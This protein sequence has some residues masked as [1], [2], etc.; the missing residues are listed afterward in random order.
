[1]QSAFGSSGR[2]FIAQIEFGW[3][4]WA[5][6][7][8]SFRATLLQKY[9]GLRQ[10]IEVVAAQIYFTGV[11][12]LPLVCGLAVVTGGLVLLQGVFN[13]QMFGGANW[14]GQILV[15][16]IVRELGPLLTA[17]VVIARSGTAIASEVGN[18]RANREI[19]AL[20]AMGI[21][22]LSYIVF[23][24]LIGGVVSLVCL[25]FFFIVSALAGGYLV[26]LF[27]VDLSLSFYFESLANSLSFADGF[28][29]LLKTTVSGVMIFMIAS[30]CGLSVQRSPTEVP[31]ATTQAVVRSIMAVV[32]FHFSVSVLYYMI[33]LGSRGVL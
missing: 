7:Y 17:L 23:P 19:E 32:I 22:P 15:V 12:A 21:H 2:W 18:M 14:L 20:E 29:F 13:L 25:T 26:T 27:A 8:L 6:A 9:Q 33:E 5:T 1:M 4:L 3:R 11:Q 24:R 31:V 10:V 28:L 30:L 16:I